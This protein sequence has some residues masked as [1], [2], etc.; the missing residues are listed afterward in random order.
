LTLNIETGKQ[1]FKKVIN[2]NIYMLSKTRY[3]LLLYR[4]EGMIY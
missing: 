1:D 2:H 4:E 3:D